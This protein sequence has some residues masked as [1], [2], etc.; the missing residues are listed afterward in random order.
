M[1][2]TFNWF[3]ASRPP[4]HKEPAKIEFGPCFPGSGLGTSYWALLRSHHISPPV[5]NV[6]LTLLI[7]ISTLAPAGEQPAIIS[8]F[9]SGLN[10][11]PLPPTFSFAFI[12]RESAKNDK[13]AI[14]GI[15]FFFI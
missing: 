6:A 15:R 1:A 4:I 5:S 10:T 14:K 13:E 3:P 12:D 2:A 7:S 9:G 11:T 8:L